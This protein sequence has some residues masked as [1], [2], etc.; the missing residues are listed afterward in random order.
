M[1]T[2]VSTPRPGTPLWTLALR[3]DLLRA[4]AE[5][6]YAYLEEGMNLPGVS[7]AQVRR[8][9]GLGDCAK[10]GLALRNGNVNLPVVLQRARR[11]FR[12]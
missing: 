2:S 7:R 3:H 10:A 5:Q 9:K 12:V 1:Y 4:P 6:P 8:L 11:T